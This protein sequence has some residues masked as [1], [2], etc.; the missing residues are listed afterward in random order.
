MTDA[1]E[2]VEDGVLTPTEFEAFVCTNPA[3]LYRDQN[4]AFFDG[5][6]LSVSAPA[7]STA[8]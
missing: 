8:S 1:F 2:M 7:A 4:P 3:R 6:V 5:T